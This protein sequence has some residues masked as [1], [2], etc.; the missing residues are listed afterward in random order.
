MRPFRASSVAVLLL[1]WSATAAC[2]GVEPVLVRQC[3]EEDAVVQRFGGDLW[4]LLLSRRCL[5][6]QG[7]VGREVLVQTR[8]DFPGPEVL[9]L[10]PD[11]DLTCRVFHA[12]FVGRAAPPPAVIRPDAGL[13]AMRE[14]LE[15]MGYYCGPLAVHGW[16]FDAALAFTRYRESR[17]LDG[18][19][20]GLR[21]AVTA[22]AIDALGGRRPSGSG[23]RRSK[24]IA[25]ESDEIVSFLVR[26]GSVECGEPTFVRG[27]AADSS[28]FTLLDGSV[29]DVLP[30][31]RGAV[32]TWLA[33]DGV[34]AC[35]GRL[36]N[37]RTGEMA[38]ATR[39]Q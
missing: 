24:R 17:R 19:E 10:V 21:R 14:T 11:L 22:I 7:Y 15:A 23:L 33:G 18:T 6:L 34:V 16:T 2:A 13:A 31:R 37:L 26:G 29:W 8:A 38:R 5:S 35:N 25:G 3:S 9:V 32:A 30:A 36:V 39:L 28:Y 4:R 27:I 1:A 12:D 20:H